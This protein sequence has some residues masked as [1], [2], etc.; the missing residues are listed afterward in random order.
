V[1][2][3]THGRAALV[4]GM[5]ASLQ[6]ARAGT[7]TE[8]EVLV[9]D[10]SGPAEAA[11]IAQACHGTGARYLRGPL[12]V[13]A[14]RNLG[15]RNTCA[16]VVLF[17]DSDCRADPDLLRE[18]LAV[19]TGAGATMA[20]ASG[21]T[22]FVGEP[23]WVWRIAEHT[24][25]LDAFG[26]AERFP[27]VQ[28]AVT[29]NLSFSRTVLEQLGGFDEGLPYRL[30]WDDID[31][32]LRATRG[33]YYILTAP[34]A[35]VYHEKATWN[36]LGGLVSRAWRWGRLRFWALRKHPWLKRTDPPKQSAMTL[37]AAGLLGAAALTRHTWWPLALLALWVPLT[38][39]L[40]AATRAL[41]HRWTLRDLGD[42]WAA[43]GLMSLHDLATGLEALR[44]GSPVWLF[45]RLI[46]SDGHLEGEYAGE[47]LRSWAHIAMLGL[48]GLALW[49]TR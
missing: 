10:S 47:V 11:H 34:H 41:S 39:L 1:V 31:L 35:V 46:F 26:F 22:R 37:V 18:H 16:P 3:P 8:V 5:L 13:R 42:E 19:W 24:P 48:T 45:Q 4:A 44:H 17:L 9:V 40:L 32:C 43:E 49:L 6:G 14:K 27:G 38:G 30:G 7:G 25:F 12:S 29:N 36:S 28:W 20:G 2:T 21:L 15:V 23:N 33:G